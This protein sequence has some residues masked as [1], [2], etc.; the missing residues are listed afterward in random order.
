MDRERPLVPLAPMTDAALN[1]EIARALNVE[2]SPEFAARVRARAAHDSSGQSDYGIRLVAAAALVVAAIA[3]LP[4]V[5]STN[6]V[7]A[8]PA[9][10]AGRSEVRALA[11]PVDR[12]RSYGV[13]PQTVTPSISRSQPAR[14]AREPDVRILAR[15]RD[16]LYALVRAISAARTLRTVVIEPSPLPT[17]DDA[18]AAGIGPLVIEPLAVS[19]GEQGARQ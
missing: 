8:P 18:A 4:L 19:A 15:D 7:V 12:S 16:A 9:P 6:R 10:L 2:P 1:A 13:E 17:A 14:A 3:T 5:R 11:L